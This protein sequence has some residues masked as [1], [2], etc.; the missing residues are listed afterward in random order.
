MLKIAESAALKAGKIILQSLDRLNTVKVSEKG[1]KDYVT[2][3]DRKSE[4]VII[5]ILQKTYPD[6]K[7]LAEESG[8][9]EGNADHLWIIDP[10][11]GTK[12]FM[13]G[14]PH[15]CV[16]IAYQERGKLQVG[17]IYDPLRDELFTAS[18]GNGAHVNNKRIRVSQQ[19]KLEN[20]LIGTGFQAKHSEHFESHFQCYKALFPHISGMRRSGSAALDLAYIAAGRL[21]GFWELM[22]SK[23]DIAAGVLMIREAGG[24]VSDPQGTEDYLE[25]GNIIAGNPKIF[26]ALLQMI[27]SNYKL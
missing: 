24:L 4:E 3:I 10:L 22:L 26:K 12:N 19:N 20:S 2:E 15:F 9:L 17:V 25:S 14:Y 21:D 13:H 1:Q 5:Q 7:I 11:D 6:H 16:S 8:E 23:W 18:R 27:S